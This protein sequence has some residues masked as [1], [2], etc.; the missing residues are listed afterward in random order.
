MRNSLLG[1]AITLLLIGGVDAEGQQ[2][3]WKK[4]ENEYFSRCQL[5]SKERALKEL[6]PSSR[7]IPGKA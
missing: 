2:E 7:S 6:T 3:R 1:V 4:I 5:L